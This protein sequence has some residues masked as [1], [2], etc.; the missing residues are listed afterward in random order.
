MAALTCPYCGTNYQV[1]QPNCSNCGAPLPLQPAEQGENLPPLEPPS[2]PRPIRDS[3]AWRILTSDGWAVVA[4][5]FTLLG[6]IFILVGGGLT[7]G[8]I[9]AFV[10]IPFLIGGLGVLAAGLAIFGF[11][12]RRARE[13]VTLIRWGDVAHG[14]VTDVKENLSVTVNNRHPW[15]INYRFDPG[16]GEL[17]GSVSTLNPP[18]EALKPGKMIYVIYSPQK[19]HLSTIYPH[20]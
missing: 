20:P 5:V 2:P 13:V 11:R 3:Y 4:F 1:F 12:F 7:L 9:T 18:G 8:I 14:E 16:Q 6:F 15:R 17:H 19:P 10:G